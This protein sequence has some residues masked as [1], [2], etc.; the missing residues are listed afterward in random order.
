[1]HLAAQSIMEMTLF[2]PCGG[3]DGPTGKPWRVSFYPKFHQTLTSYYAGL[4]TGYTKC[5][6][7]FSNCGFQRLFALSGFCKQNQTSPNLAAS[8][9]TNE[10]VTKP[11]NG[12][13][14]FALSIY[15][16]S[17]T[18]SL[19]SLGNTCEISTLG[20]PLPQPFMDRCFLPN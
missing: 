16:Q 15:I 11:A 19:H 10:S 17:V 20:L 5:R 13:F 9:F 18:P 6:L 3:A 7:S 1:M 2:I 14:S 8:R 12:H 4:T